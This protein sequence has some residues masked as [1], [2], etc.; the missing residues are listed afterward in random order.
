MAS[1]VLPAQAEGQSTAELAIVLP[2]LMILLLTVVQVGLVAR[3]YVAIHHSVGEAARRAALEP[4]HL[5]DLVD[6]ASPSGLEPDRLQLGMEG[7]RAT[8][9]LLTVRLDYQSPTDVPVVGAFVGDVELSTSAVV[10]VE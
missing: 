8:G 3:D 1:Q 9:D 4:D 7:G 10:R 2:L 5:P 6:V